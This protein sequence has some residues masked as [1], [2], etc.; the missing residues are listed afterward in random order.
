[1]V[2]NVVE[3]NAT[4]DPTPRGTA[5]EVETEP[6][7]AEDGTEPEGEGQDSE[8]LADLEKRSHPFD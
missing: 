2:S 1:V 3:T 6:A 5:D 8:P 4:T 7:P